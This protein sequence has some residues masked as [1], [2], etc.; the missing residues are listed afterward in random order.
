[1]N[2][3]IFLY[4]L[5]MQAEKTEVDWILHNGKIYTIDHNFSLAQAMAID[6]GKI[7][8]VGTDADILSKYSSSKI[9]NLKE[10]AVYPGFIDAHCHFISYGIEQSYAQL[11]GTKSFNEILEIIKNH[12]ASKTGGW[13]IGR[14]WD[15]NDWEIKEFPDCKE[16]DIL[17]PNTPVYLI[18]IDGHAAVANTKALE[19]AGIHAQTKINGGIIKTEGDKC[20]GL[21][22]DNAMEPIAKLLPINQKAFQQNAI[23]VA[24]KECFAVGLTSVHDAGL[25]T[26]QIQFIEELQKREI[27]KMRMNVMVSWSDSNY[28]YF[29]EHG[30]IKTQKLN[31]SS[32]KL[33]A[34]GALGSRG[35]ALLD[36]YSDDAGNKGL[37]FYSYD[38]LQNIAAKIYAMNFQ[39][40]THAI[41]DAA[42]RLVLD[43]Y[44]SVL[45]HENNL[46]WRIEHCQVIQPVDF[47]KFAEYSIIP[48]VQ[49]THATSD[50]YWA[51][52]RLGNTRI[53]SAYA[54]L[55]LKKIAGMVACGSDFP[56]ENINPL[57]GF[58]AAVSRKDQ[59]AF[60]D[61][62]FQRKNALSR[63]DA[64]KGMTI[65][66]AYAAFEEQEKG[67][68]E[69]NKY[70][71][72]VVLDRDIMQVPEKEIFSAQV[73]MTVSG[74]EIVYENTAE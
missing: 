58:Y 9:T 62:G 23:M 12:D 21:L 67:S 53:T 26:W 31:V 65:W 19:M 29:L 56:V 32:F 49:P 44:G 22:I 30:K 5:L 43:T 66:A 17:F 34:D 72:F 71:D 57:Y 51:N 7:V 16:L 47:N 73:L 4:S 64:L 45:K 69:K 54:Y 70:A 8:E 48:S 2:V 33:Y 1:M 37:L 38:S 18:R 61:S 27:L 6:N 74:G 52:E 50:M 14:G 24:Q 15:Q 63:E 42:N 25:D 20:T 68:I 36:D 46:R 10:K 41:G 55:D 59:S 11:Y 35:A 60:P 40:C 39:M 28:Q 3:L 13:I